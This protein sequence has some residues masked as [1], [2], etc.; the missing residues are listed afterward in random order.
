MRG[1]LQ[2][3]VRSLLV[4][5]AISLLAVGCQG[6]ASSTSAVP[7]TRSP[8]PGPG[9]AGAASSSSTT[10]SDDHGEHDEHGR[11]SSARRVELGLTAPAGTIPSLSGE[12]WSD[13]EAVA[14]RFVLADTTY[15]AAEDPATVNV[16]RAAYASPRLAS[17]LATSSSGG[18]RLEELR[19]RQARFA[20]EVLTIVTNENSGH[21]A[22]IEITAAVTTTRADRPP[23]RRVRF[24]RL[25]LGR[26]SPTG[27]WLVARVEQS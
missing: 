8:A 5:T 16:R 11:L 19:R 9:A 4:L 24:Y 20:G 25:T 6:Q 3:R 21:L 22:V 7:T 17:D 13:P 2:P 26:D 1:R 27:R 10:V 23:E 15:A 18:A 14:C 12:L